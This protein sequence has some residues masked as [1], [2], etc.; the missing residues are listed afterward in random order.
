MK[1]NCLHCLNEDQDKFTATKNGFICLVCF[2][3]SVNKT[4]ENQAETAQIE[5][6]K[7]LKRQTGGNNRR[8]TRAYMGMRNK[9]AFL[10][11]LPDK[12]EAQN[13]FT[14]GFRDALN[15]F[16]TESR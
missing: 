10:E 7:H 15:T 9:L 2:E 6:E 4:P 16:E 5:I 8:F 12:T 13:N 1:L 3:K 11:S 14:L